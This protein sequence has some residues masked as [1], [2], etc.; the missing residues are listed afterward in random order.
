MV[1]KVQSARRPDNDGDFAAETPSGDRYTAL[2]Q[3]EGEGCCRLEPISPTV[4]LLAQQVVLCPSMTASHPAWIAQARATGT[5]RLAEA[6]FITA[7]PSGCPFA[8]SICLKRCRCDESDEAAQPGS[9]HSQYRDMAVRLAD[10]D[11]ER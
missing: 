9:E 6:C 2:Y 1:A 7:E 3:E 5:E 10:K 8:F 11:H 4:T